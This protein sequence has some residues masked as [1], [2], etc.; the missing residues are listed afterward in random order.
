[1]C[2]RDRVKP[3]NRERIQAAE[4]SGA[5]KVML[6]SKVK[7]IEPDSVTMVDK[8]GKQFDMPNEVI[9][10]C[11]GGILPTGFLKEVG[12]QVETRFGT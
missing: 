9:V 7:K 5:I 10:V 11:A 6:Q 2:I 1:M 12:I 3:K 8:D 4:Q